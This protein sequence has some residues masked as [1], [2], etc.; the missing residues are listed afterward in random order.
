MIRPVEH[1]LPLTNTVTPSEQAV[2]AEVVERAFHDSTAVYPI[3]GGTSLTYG[4]TPKQT[5]IGLSLAGLQRIVDYPARDLTITAEAG[6]PISVLAQQLAA[7]RQRLPVDIPQAE[8][9]TLGGVV[10]ASPSGPRRF[11]WGTMRDFVIGVR[12]VDGRGTAFSGG[13]RVV[14]NAAGYD[15]CRLLTGSMGTLGVITQVTLMV[16]PV[17]ETSAFLACTPADF[18]MAERLLSDLIR[19]KTLP[20]AVELLAGPAWQSEPAFEANGGAAHLLVGFEGAEEEVQW[21][22]E[23]LR[24]EWNKAGAAES[25]AMDR[26]EC[27]RLWSRL[28]EFPA[29][30]SG[31]EA[32]EPLVVE[33]GV[34]PSDT[35]R[36]FQELL[37][38]DPDCSIQ[39]HAGNG[40]LRAK[41]EPVDDGVEEKLRRLRATIAAGGGSLVVLRRPGHC[42][43]GPT[44]IWGEPAAG[45]EVMRAIKSRFDPK[46]IL[47]PDRFLFSRS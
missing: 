19:T 46:G 45:A 28:T 27:D 2:V 39:A 12:A 13:G 6:I 20:A 11:R 34:L 29:V 21:M 35:V 4:A 24:E 32:R 43:W 41:F 18:N 7:E 17:P 16:K 23:Q 15:L 9:A 25:R 10:A 44:T 36:T 26:T 37:Q 3:G 31:P 42:D 14:K 22:V 47:N 5:G 33:V 40:V 1:A 30:D 38:L 8:Q